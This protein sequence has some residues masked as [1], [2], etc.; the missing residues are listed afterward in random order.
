[1]FRKI[2]VPT[3][4][5]EPAAAALVLA[6]DLARPL[7]TVI[8]LV[9]VIQV[10]RM[11]FPDG[12]VLMATPAEAADL[13]RS[14]ASALEAARRTCPASVATRVLEGS[15]P[16]SIVEVAEA[17]DLI[18]MGTHGRGGLSHLLLGSVAEKVLRVARCPV[19]IVGSAAV[20]ARHGR[21]VH[22]PA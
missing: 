8:E 21:A 22:A 2:I 17:D 13:L 1:M 16:E 15:V 14:A 3:D 4:F 10:P 18:V 11:A 6:C 20:A 7:G 9:H 12:S 5:S 19:L